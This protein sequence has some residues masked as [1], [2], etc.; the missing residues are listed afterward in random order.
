M[1]K[2]ILFFKQFKFL[3]TA[4]LRLYHYCYCHDNVSLYVK[5]YPVVHYAPVM[6]FHATSRQ[7]TRVR[8]MSRVSD[9]R[10]HVLRVTRCLRRGVYFEL[11]CLHIVSIFIHL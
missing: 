11:Q 9:I 3:S 1:K 2:Y 6:L 7:N 8:H 5:M 10:V 4:D